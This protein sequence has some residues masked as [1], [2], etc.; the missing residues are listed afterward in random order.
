MHEREREATSYSV[1]S[2]RLNSDRT[3]RWFSTDKSALNALSRGRVDS[4]DIKTVTDS[5]LLDR[6]NTSFF[7]ALL[8]PGKLATTQRHIARRW[9]DRQRP[10][11]VSLSCVR[12]DIC[13]RESI[14]LVRFAGMRAVQMDRR[15]YIR[16]AADLRRIPVENKPCAR[17][18]K[19]GSP[20]IDRC[21]NDG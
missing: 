7:L 14:S 16:I 8:F 6:C 17:N 18:R 12:N 15:L 19:T 5:A 9:P 10:E 21:R 3:A 20:T 1:P 13:Y 11:A 4:Q 2:K